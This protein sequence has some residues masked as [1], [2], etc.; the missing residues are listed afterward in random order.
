MMITAELAALYRRPSEPRQLADDDGTQPVLASAAVRPGLRDVLPNKREAAPQSRRGQTADEQTSFRRTDERQA[1]QEESPQ[2]R[3]RR[4]SHQ[5][6]LID[7][8]VTRGRRASDLDTV[9]D[10]AI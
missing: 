8:R 9:I 2:P 7:T 3:D 1:D 4:Q 6:V 5:A 10:F